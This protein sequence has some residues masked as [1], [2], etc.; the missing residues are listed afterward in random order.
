VFS[1]TLSRLMEPRMR[2]VAAVAL[3]LA[4]ALPAFA[5][6]PEP[7]KPVDPARLAGRWYEV[8]RLPSPYQKD[9]VASTFDWTRNKD[10]TLGVLLTCR[11]A[12][13]KT[14]TQRA[15]ATVLDA[16]T[17]AKLRVS[18]M[19]GLASAQYH[20]LDRADDYSWML[21]GTSGGRYMWVLSNRP[22]LSADARRQAI[23]RAGSLGYAVNRL[24]QAP[25]E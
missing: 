1:A 20:V 7:R 24:I 15:K 3:S 11:T 10:G 9:C 8:A 13:G 12:A 17:N 22:K 16:R 6:A 21:L 4:L 18:F 2:I 23:A 25:G 19:G 5:A 14:N